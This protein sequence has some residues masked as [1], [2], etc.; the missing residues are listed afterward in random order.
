[1]TQVG[2]HCSDAGARAQRGAEMATLDYQESPAPR[3][4]PLDARIIGAVLTCGYCLVWIL[5]MS[6][7]LSFPIPLEEL[8]LRIGYHHVAAASAPVAV[9]W[10]VPIFWNIYLAASKEATFGMR[11][12]NL[13]FVRADGTPAM[14]PDCAF[15]ALVGICCTPLFPLSLWTYSRDS[16]RWLLADSICRVVVVMKR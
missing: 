10:G 9:V 4:A 14:K 16:R 1:M 13:C 12:S 6:F 2:I 11:H 3:G 15:R 7:V 5:P 8:M